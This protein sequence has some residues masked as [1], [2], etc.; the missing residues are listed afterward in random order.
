MKADD[1]P[2]IDRYLEMMAVERGASANSL[3]AYRTDLVK[4]SAVLPSGLAVAG[5]DEL[6]ALGGE[7][8]DLAHASVA[9][10][11]SALR[12]FYGFLIDEGARDDD[13]SDALPRPGARRSLPKIL[14]LEE[15]DALFAVIAERTNR[16]HPRPQDVRLSALVELLYGSGLRATE[17]VSL[18]RTAVVSDR[19][20]LIIKGKGGKERL[21]PISD[22]ARMACQTWKAM[23]DTEKDKAKGRLAF[24]IADRPYHP[25]PPFPNHPRIGGGGGIGPAKGQ[26]PRPSSRLCH[27]FVVGRRGSSRVANDVGPCRYCDD[28]N[29]YARRQR[30]FGRIGQSSSPFGENGRYEPCAG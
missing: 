8:A 2:L 27:A 10:K 6:A 24:P 26:P 5:R 4:A 25:H 16:P 15:V 12:G 9:R 30:A 21:V 11:A 23:I 28:G 20:F 19:P 1:A 22:R 3:S 14:S 13:P 18:P 17:L 7:W 29:L